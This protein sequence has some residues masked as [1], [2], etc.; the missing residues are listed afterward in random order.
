MVVIKEQVFVKG[1]KADENGRFGGCYVILHRDSETGKILFHQ[2]LYLKDKDEYAQYF[3][4]L[5]P[6]DEMQ[7]RHFYERLELQIKQDEELK[8]LCDNFGVDSNSYFKHRGELKSD[9]A[10]SCNV[11]NDNSFV[12]AKDL[13]KR[14]D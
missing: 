5:Y 2:A 8:T 9:F 13:S 10:H 7:K 11:N 4:F 14:C 3:G 1:W 6:L 12:N